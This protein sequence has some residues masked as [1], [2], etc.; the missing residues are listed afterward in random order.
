MKRKKVSSFY[1]KTHLAQLIRDAEA[2]QS[3]LIE[4][5]GK[6]VARLEP[7]G[8]VPGECD[9]NALADEF[10]A[11]RKRGKPGPSVRELIEEG[12]RF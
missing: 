2:G 7:V 5:H 3:F 10:R 1:A 11:L 4:R 9:F 8:E 6:P 12:R